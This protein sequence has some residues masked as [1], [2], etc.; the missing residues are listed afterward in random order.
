MANPMPYAEQVKVQEVALQYRA[1]ETCHSLRWPV[2]LTK[3]TVNRVPQTI[4]RIC[5]HVA[6]K[7][8]DHRG[9]FKHF[10]FMSAS[11]FER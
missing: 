10:A 3:L 7:M 6:E 1:I 8:G 4:H 5:P 2:K 9:R 11:A